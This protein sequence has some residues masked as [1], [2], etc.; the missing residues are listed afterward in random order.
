MAEPW[1]WLSFADGSLPDGQ[2]FL[3]V[4]IMQG[5]TIEAV[6]TESHL[7]NLNPGGEVQYVQIPPEHV[8]APEYR[9]RLLGKIELEEAGLA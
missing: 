4:A 2:Q 3:G 9:N 8:P 1:W 7:R 6:I 5:Y